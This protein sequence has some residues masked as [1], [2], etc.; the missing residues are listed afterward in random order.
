MGDSGCMFASRL[1]RW[2]LDRLRLDGADFL[3]AR[4]ILIEVALERLAA[5]AILS[6]AKPADHRVDSVMGGLEVALEILQ[7]I[8]QVLGGPSE[9]DVAHCDLHSPFRS[10]ERRVGKASGCRRPR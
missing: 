7:R 8:L 6:G 10:E 9:A 3:R 2:Q 5:R 4:Y 1:A